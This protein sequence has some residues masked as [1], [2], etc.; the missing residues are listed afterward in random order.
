MNPYLPS[1]LEYFWLRP[2][3]AVWRALDCAEL[4][5]IKFAGP[6]IDIGCG[7]GALS[8]MRAGGRYAMSYDFSSQAGRLDKFFN[9]EDIYNHFDASKLS[10]IIARPACYQIDVGLDHKQAL[11]DK[12]NLTG[13]Y[14]ET[15]AGDANRALP[16]D[17]ASFTT[18]YSNIL[19]WLED[20]PTTLREITRILRPGGRC[21][22]QVP[23]ENFRNFSFYQRLF[24]RTGDP[25]W[26]WLKL[27]DRGR[28]ENIK[29]CKSADDWTADFER[30]GLMVE[31]C[32]AYMPRLVLEAWDI[33]LRP[34][35]PMLIEMAES[36]E[37]SRRL[38]IK[39]KWVANM[40]PLLSP[41]CEHSGT[42]NGFLLFVLTRSQTQ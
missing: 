11:L 24:V 32:S 33:G 30:A 27:I 41:L 15:I 38:E 40:L 29:N 4:D 21:I 13:L 22:L 18:V 28:S 36:L 9:G 16:F 37:S 3:T 2:E 25:K 5:G 8:F 14:K 20:Y 12:A 23:S 17:D 42:E 39:E 1:L 7:D 6:S 26:E 31:R 10:D 19:Y 34:I 35:S